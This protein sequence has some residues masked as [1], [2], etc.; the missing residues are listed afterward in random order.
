MSILQRFVSLALTLLVAVPC[1]AR[2]A[3]ADGYESI[4]DGKT[5]TGW[6]GNPELWRVENGAIV[7]QTSPDK[8]LEANTFL[9]WR[10]GE[11]G[12]FDLKVEFKIEGGNSG[13]QYRSFEIPDSK[14]G[15]GGYQADFDADNKH[16]GLNYGEKFRGM[17]SKR[18]EKATIGANHKPTVNGSVGDPDELVKVIKNGDWN[19][20]HITARRF[21]FTQAIN[22]TVMSE[23]TDDDKEQRRATG[24]LAFQVH[25]LPVGQGMK[26]QFRN[27]R[28]KR[29]ADGSGG[30]TSNGG[31][32]GDGRKKIAFVAGK[33]SHG[34]G[35]HEH[36]A[37]CML[38]A[39]ALNESGLPVKAEVYYYG[40]PEDSSV[41]DDADAI[42]CYA[43]GGAKHP[44]N[45]H[46]AEVDKLAKKGVGLTFLHYG[47]ETVIGPE[48]DAF[49]RCMGG[50]F[51]INYS[52]N[53]H[54]TA[55]YRKLPEH[56]ISRGV[57]PFAINDEWYYHMRFRAGMEGVTPILTALPGSET[58]SRKDG[59]HSGNPEVR[60]A[61]ARG[62]PQCM[63][64]ASENAGGGRGFGFT[65][66]HFHWNW[67]HDQFRKLVLNAIVWTAKVDVPVDGVTSRSLTM[68]DLM[69]NQD[70]PTP[71]KFD[72]KPIEAMLIEWK[73]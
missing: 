17:L 33:P 57:K 43:D 25:K 6:D 12:D 73:K 48:E 47:V 64:W 61:I 67:G 66:G 46:L 50:T 7:G 16:T 56:A 29:L 20:Y 26:V 4:F 18:G 13:I 36:R 55:D 59:H 38:L 27:V 70:E 30:S 41:L 58:L 9:I 63:A 5:L 49:L 32:G 1:V 71:E 44:F 2:A 53:P 19:E 68:A 52:V 15:V 10:G 45:E 37:G 35:S 8:P 11:V 54:W 40:W 51:E 31:G 3:D 42:V 60:A 69:A 24:I 72:P 21:H 14:W 22:G 65:G 23:L 28:L 34:F 39:N 62:E